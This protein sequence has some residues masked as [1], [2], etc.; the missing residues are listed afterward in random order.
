LFVAKDSQ[1]IS[2]LNDLLNKSQTRE[3][4]IENVRDKLNKKVYDIESTF[5]NMLKSLQP[6]AEENS[7]QQESN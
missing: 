3:D 5:Q 1:L 6:V 2:K 4:N 7:A